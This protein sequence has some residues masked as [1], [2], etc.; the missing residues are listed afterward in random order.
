MSLV[1][2]IR[3]ILNHPL[4]KAQKINAL[5]RFLRWQVGSRIL[6]RPVIIDYVSGARLIVKQGMMGATGN[7][8]TGLHEFEDMAFVLHALRKE[9]T[10]VDIGANIG[11]YTVLAGKAVGAKCISIEPILSTFSCLIDNIQLN[12][13]NDRVLA[14]NIGVGRETGMLKFTAGLD[15]VNHVLSDT[16]AQKDSIEI[17]VKKLD[18]ILIK[19][20]PYLIKIDVEGFE[21]E[22]IA[23]A[24]QIL[25]RKSLNAVIM[26]LNGS[27]SHYGYDEVQ[28][29]KQ[30]LSHG[31]LSYQYLPLSRK[32]ITLAGKNADSGNTLYIKDAEELMARVK[33]ASAFT[34]LANSI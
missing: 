16:E 2:T 33:S 29:H 9:D 5:V 4:N 6:R 32:L 17:P 25:S 11:S 23:G 15:T 27:G 10:F 20:E 21:T 3:F 24:A 26:E 7:I 14:L 22:V 30:M 34:S 19:T 8:Y 13:I 1:H 18:D 12:N 28:L 31:F